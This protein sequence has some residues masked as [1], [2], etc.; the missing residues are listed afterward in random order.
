[1]APEHRI[2]WRLLF[3]PEA[4]P[5][6]RMDGRLAASLIGLPARHH[7]ATSTS[8]PT[9]RSRPA[10][11]SAA[12][13]SACPPARRWRARSAPSRSRATR[14]GWEPF[15]W[16]GETPLWLYVLR[17]ADVRGGG[18]RLGEVGGRLVAEVLLGLLDA[19]PES[20]R[21][22]GPRLG[23]D[24]PGGGRAL[25]RARP[26]GRPAVSAGGRG[27]P[28]LSLPDELDSRRLRRRVVQVTALF[29]AIALLAWLAPGLDSI[30]SRLDHADPAWLV[31]GV[32]LEV[33]SCACYVLMFGPVFCER[34]ALRTSVEIG[35]AELG[36]GSLIPAGGLGGLALGV[37]ALR[38]GGMPTD[39]V[40]T[41]SVAFFLIKCAANFA[42]VAVVGIVMWLGVGRRRSRRR[43]PSCRR[44]SRWRSWP[45]SRSLP[46]FLARASGDG[47]VA[48]AARTL[49][50]GVS[51]ALR[52]LRTGNPAIVLGSLG[53]WAFDNLVLWA[54][55]RGFGVHVALTVVL[56][57][58]L[59][60]QLGGLLPIPGG[61]GG[62][63]GGLVGTLVVYGVSLRDAV[64][65]VLA[66]RVIQFW[67]PLLL[68]LP[69]FVS[70]QRGLNRP[71]RPDLCAPPI[72]PE[73]DPNQARRKA[74][75]AT[76]A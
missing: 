1:M 74:A 50:R 76:A 31:L 27:G 46:V 52:L 53:Y 63:E 70:L 58:Y 61:L 51:E 24:A 72:W 69:A 42:A 29:V 54:C 43:S 60:G 23:A 39:Q 11:C 32:A 75:C 28:T 13:P 15:G 35:L 45:A 67:I 59:I 41:R 71:E 7:A 19:D 16:Q 33:A 73:R 26:A 68:S 4:Q 40:A 30:R 18:E 36:V 22:A 62:V 3:G 14:P 10:T 12:P 55:F 37:W 34:M 5:A 48:R 44:C 49:G 65:A 56:M 2:D 25:R 21:V 9:T 8:R 64:A 38:R 47:R 6:K 20:Y 17:E 66:Y 57:G